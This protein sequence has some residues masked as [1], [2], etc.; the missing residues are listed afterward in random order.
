M[1]RLPRPKIGDLDLYPQLSPEQE[2]LLCIVDRA[3]RDALSEN[4]VAGYVSNCAVPSEEERDEA[5]EYILSGQAAEL[6]YQAGLDFD[7]CREHLPKLLD[8]NTWRKG[9]WSLVSTFRR[10]TQV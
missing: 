1:S 8:S 7:Y 2:L 3:F 6:L 9:R 5:R 10:F 4:I